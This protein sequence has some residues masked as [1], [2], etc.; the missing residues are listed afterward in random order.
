MSQAKKTTSVGELRKALAEA[1][2]H[3]GAFGKNLH[4]SKDVVL[5]I[6]GTERHVS[7]LAVSFVDGA[8]VFV[9]L[10]GAN[11]HD[12]AYDQQLVRYISPFGSPATL[13]RIDAV[14]RLQRDDAQ[15]LRW[16]EAEQ[17]GAGQLISDRMHE[18]GPPRIEEIPK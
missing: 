16:Q 2:D 10:A 15:W 13:R 3:G 18:T 11:V 6:D 8:F 14:K 5:N 7:Q 9:L 12:P 4:E 1:M 17:E